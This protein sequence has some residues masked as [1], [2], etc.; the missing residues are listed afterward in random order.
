[1]IIGAAA[2]IK[3]PEVSVGLLLG[4][5]IPYQLWN[6]HIELRLIK[7]AGERGKCKGY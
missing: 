4:Y 6:R 5:R 3:L 2:L 7:F 1:M